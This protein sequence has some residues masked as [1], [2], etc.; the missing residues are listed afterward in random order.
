MAT[1]VYNVPIILAKC[2]RLVGI[3]SQIALSQS[4]GGWFRTGGGEEKGWEYLVGA[5]RRRRIQH[6][7]KGGGGGSPPSRLLVAER[8]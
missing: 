7:V 1:W 5:R 8:V 3:N 2:W 4:L 6:L